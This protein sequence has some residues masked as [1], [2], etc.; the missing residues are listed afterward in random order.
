M[1]SFAPLISTESPQ[2]LKSVKM[3]V[4]W[5]IFTLGEWISS[6]PCWK[7]AQ[8]CRE[9]GEGSILHLHLADAFIQSDLLYIQAIHFFNEYVCSLGIEP[10]TFCAANAM[11]YHWATRTS[12]VSGIC[13]TS[14]S[15]FMTA[16]IKHNSL[17]P[18]ALI[19]PYRRASLHWTSLWSFLQS[20]VGTKHFSLYS[21]SNNRTF[22]MLLHP[23]WL[24]WSL[25]SMD[26]QKSLFSKYGPWKRLN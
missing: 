2:L 23:K 10:T 5:R 25:E 18:S 3:H 13:I 1:G 21:S 22:W 8:Q 9:W 7:N 6:L 12:S 20:M 19:H 11:L 15:E 16:L 14:H 17:T 24:T 26:S 4:H